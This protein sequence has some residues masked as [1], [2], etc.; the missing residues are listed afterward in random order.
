MNCER[1]RNLISAYLDQ[2][3]RPEEARLIRAHLVTCDACNRELEAETALKEALGGLASCEAPEDFLPTLLARLDCERRPSQSWFPACIFRY[4]AMGAAAAVLALAVVP[5]VRQRWGG[6][7]V[8]EA[9]TLYRQHSLVTAA[10][11]LADRALT[12]YYYE[13]AGGVRREAPGGPAA[14][15]VK[16]VGEFLSE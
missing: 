5:L 8:V 10:Q 9:Q 16:L 2:E 7:Y 13:V 12:G 15:R 14:D 6:E 11:P 3:L 4:A 1:V